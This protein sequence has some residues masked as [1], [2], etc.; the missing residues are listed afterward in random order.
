ME[1]VNFE[2]LGKT[3]NIRWFSYSQNLCRQFQNFLY[4]KSC[5]VYYIILVIG[6]VK[7]CVW[8]N[9]KFSDQYLYFKQKLGIRAWMPI[10][11]ARTK[12]K[13]FLLHFSGENLVLDTLWRSINWSHYENIDV[14]IHSVTLWWQCP[15]VYTDVLRCG[16]LF[17]L[18][19]A[20][21][22]NRVF[23][24]NIDFYNSAVPNTRIKH[25]VV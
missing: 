23:A 10:C 1:W 15:I 17:F 21:I 14:F 24:S 8:S 18:Y 9:E 25:L 12:K 16:I 7:H 5:Q 4:V 13:R 3:R 11:F 22:A 2:N 6:P 20:I 19:C